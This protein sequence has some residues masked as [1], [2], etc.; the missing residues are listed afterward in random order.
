MLDSCGAHSY[1]LESSEEA[2][3]T[4]TDCLQDADWDLRQSNSWEKLVCSTLNFSSYPTDRQGSKIEEGHWY[5][6]NSGFRTSSQKRKHSWFKSALC[7]IQHKASNR[8]SA[9]TKQTLR[10][11]DVGNLQSLRFTGAG[12]RA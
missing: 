2:H 12:T 11:P 1:C 7:L 5:L 3:L 4:P 9:I 6:F 8:G 10:Y